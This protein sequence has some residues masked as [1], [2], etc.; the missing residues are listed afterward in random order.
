MR[1]LKGKRRNHS[2]GAHYLKQTHSVRLVRLPCH[3]LRVQDM[4]QG[5]GAATKNS[6]STGI[7]PQLLTPHFV[8]KKQLSH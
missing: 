1:E 6:S 8:A 5:K 4:V 2:G 7:S 3:H